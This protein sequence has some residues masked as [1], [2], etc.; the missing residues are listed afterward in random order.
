MIKFL[1][2]SVVAGAVSL[3]AIADTSAASRSG[4]ISGPRGTSTYAGSRSCSG[5]SCSSQG[6]VTGPY[7]NTISHQGSRSCA[8][9]VCSGSGTVTGPRGGAVYYNSSVTR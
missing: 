9:G 7:G 2:V 8:N 4:S 3:A 6:S 5:G 1:A